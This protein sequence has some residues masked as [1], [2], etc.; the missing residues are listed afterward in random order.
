[1]EK[2]MQIAIVKMLADGK[3]PKQIA[4][5]IGR[6]SRTIESYIHLMLKVNDCKNTTNLVA[7]FLRNKIIV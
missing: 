6:S 3:T 7:E 2:Q 1:M 5:V 4:P